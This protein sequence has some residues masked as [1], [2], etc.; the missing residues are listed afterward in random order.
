MLTKIINLILSNLFSE[1]K[2]NLIQINVI[3]KSSNVSD[4]DGR[5][6]C[7]AI[8][9][10]V[11]N[12]VVPAW[13]ISEVKINYYRSSAPN[14][15]R[16]VVEIVNK[17]SDDSGSLGYHYEYQDVFQGIITTDIIFNMGGTSLKNGDGGLTV[18]NVLSHEILEMLLDPI[19]NYW[20]EGNKLKLTDE[21]NNQVSCDLYA[22]EIC[23]PVQESCY[24]IIV[25]SV[26]VSVSNFVYPDWFNMIDAG[27]DPT[28]ISKKKYDH[29]AL[30]WRPFTLGIGGYMIVKSA[31]SYYSVYGRT[32]NGNT[33]KVNAFHR[34]K[35]C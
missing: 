20:A 18:S 29:M 24:D 33:P 25:N 12:H 4:T 21:N 7:S 31:E 5:L 10:Q 28:K 14:N 15:T 3:N 8:E 23:D 13:G 17:D 19:A 1:K 9:N 2:K 22:L 32:K 16:Y 6:M 35:K 34:R 26:K 30:L 11:N 27:E